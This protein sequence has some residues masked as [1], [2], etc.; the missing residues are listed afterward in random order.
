M[1]N[2]TQK[3]GLAPRLGLNRRRRI[4]PQQ[5]PPNRP[6]QP[7]PQIPPQ[8]PQVPPQN[9]GWVNAQNNQPQ[10]APQD[11][12]GANQRQ[13]MAEAKVRF[14]TALKSDMSV[15][16]QAKQ[17]AL[18]VDGEKIRQKDKPAEN[19]LTVLSV[20]L[21]QEVLKLEE[22]SKNVRIAVG[23]K[24]YVTA[25]TEFNAGV[26]LA[27]E[28]S[29]QDKTFQEILGKHNEEPVL[30]LAGTGLSQ[31]GRDFRRR[32]ENSRSFIEELLETKSDNPAVM[33]SI[34]SLLESFDKMLEADEQ[35]KFVDAERLFDE[36]M[37]DA[38]IVSALAPVA[39]KFTAELLY[40]TP[41]MK[42]VW[43]LPNPTKNELENQ[44][45]AS[46]AYDLAVKASLKGDFVTAHNQLNLAREHADLLVPE[47]VSEARAYDANWENVKSRLE[48]SRDIPSDSPFVKKLQGYVR[49]FLVDIPKLADELKFETA[50]LAMD[51]AVGTT[52]AVHFAVRCWDEFIRTKEMYSEVLSAA[53][54]LTTDEKS[55]VEQQTTIADSLKQAE[56]LEG[57]GQHPQALGELKNAQ[58]SAYVVLEALG[59]KGVA[60]YYREAENQK[61]RFDELDKIVVQGSLLTELKKGY[62]EARKLLRESVAQ[63]QFDTALLEL[64]LCQTR[65]YYIE[66]QTKKY[67][68]IEAFKEAYKNAFTLAA[69]ADGNLAGVAAPQLL[70]AQTLQLVDPLMDTDLVRALA[71]LKQ[72]LISANKVNGIVESHQKQKDRK[73][74]LDDTIGRAAK[75]YMPPGFTENLKAGTTDGEDT[76]WDFFLVASEVAENDR[77]DP[78]YA[79]LENSAKAWLAAYAEMDEDA[80][81]DPK[82]LKHKQAC[83]TAQKQARHL[84]LANKYATL[85]DLPW[86]QA[87]EDKAADLQM[88]V[89]FE[90][91]ERP[92]EKAGEGAMGAKWIMSTDFEKDKGRKEFVFKEAFPLVAPVIPGFPPG[93]EAP[94]EVIGDE[95]GKQLKL[96]TGLDFNVPE[97]R[98]VTIDNKKLDPNRESKDVVGSAQAGASTIGSIADLVDKDPGALKKVSAKSMQKAAIFD[99]LALNLDRHSGNFLVTPP[100]ES[101]ESELVPIDNGLAFPSRLAVDVRRGRAAAGSSFNDIPSAF[102]PFDPESLAA[103]EMIDETEIINGL[104]SRTASLDQ[105]HPSL[106]VSQTMPDEAIDQIKRRVQFMKAAAPRVSPGTMMDLILENAPA[107]FDTP[108]NEK[109]N[110]FDAIIQKGEKRDKDVGP[111]VAMN[112]DEKYEL[113]SELWNLGWNHGFGDAKDPFLRKLAIPLFKVWSLRNPRVALKLAQLKK[114]NTA[115][116]AE[117]NK[118]VD[119]IKFID[120]NSKVDSQLAGL[121]IGKARSEVKGILEKTKEAVEKDATTKAFKLDFPNDSAPN[122]KTLANYKLYVKYDAKKFK[123]FENQDLTK[124][125]F[126]ERWAIV[127]NFD[128]GQKRDKELANEQIEKIQLD[129]TFVE[130]QKEFDK[131]QIDLIIPKEPESVL[132]LIRDWVQL[133]S[134]GGI[135]AFV[136]CG[137]DYEAIRKPIDAVIWILASRS[138]EG[139]DVDA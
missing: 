15:I 97:T 92:M 117:T 67:N 101:G 46:K 133:K 30:E 68:A 20:A 29:A 112:D 136:T 91:G 63:G 119:Q 17:F 114:P 71:T 48:K 21:Q 65:A 59:G 127:S 86:D 110:V 51:D 10:N 115:L 64:E 108:E 26:K 139:V 109:D 137:G 43:K 8:N 85:G 44:G 53:T 121:S 27:R 132:K 69:N 24:N 41:L 105:E 36:T 73:K 47:G 23:N 74:E 125:S 78:A 131:Y 50:N 113:F 39:E 94:R 76:L 37:E 72:A 75:T 6:Q 118:I 3:L 135:E 80:K 56:I 52:Q 83:E 81:Q 99:A 45:L 122:F 34:K 11:I 128:Y 18:T 14:E 90:T 103:I 89:F 138:T 19:E 107:I 129:P 79:N 2:P 25:E 49:D 87:T 61:R 104:K 111:F 96:A 42:I 40:L 60:A 102:E 33:G 84:K 58:T 55:L 9:P 22:H 13:L 93:S 12:I 123:K 120:P 38:Q 106:N 98:L 32:L 70:L 100:D 116:Q 66:D 77:N 95:L 124:L 126:D 54:K 16:Q 82:I 1:E 88:Q 134:L 28:I 4:Q 5:I 130:L 62:D 31:E 7:V 57:N 35:E